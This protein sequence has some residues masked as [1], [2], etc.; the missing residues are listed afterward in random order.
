MY[1]LLLVG[2][3]LH[4]ISIMGSFF[5]LLGVPKVILE[6]PCDVFELAHV[7]LVVCPYLLHLL[8]SPFLN[9]EICTLV[10]LSN[11]DFPSDVM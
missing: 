6:T 8:E 1:G 7:S 9:I 10:H 3:V 2:F 5:L 11:I 4:S